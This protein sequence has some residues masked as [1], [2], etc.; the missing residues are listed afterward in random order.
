MV[1]ME[2]ITIQEFIDDWREGLIF[3]PLIF[4]DRVYG[5]SVR[6]M[7]QAAER[8]KIVYAD[9]PATMSTSEAVPAEKKSVLS[10]LAFWR[11]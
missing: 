9:I 5:K 8:F 1:D 4:Q 11:K 10:R 2:Q 7:A 6:G 3:E